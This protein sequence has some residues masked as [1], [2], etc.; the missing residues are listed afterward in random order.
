MDNPQ[1]YKLIACEILFRELSYC[2]AQSR[3]IIDVTFMPKGLHDMGQSKMSARLQA[4]IDQ[5]DVSQYAA[6]LFG[7]GLCNNG[8]RG[9]R[10]P[11]PMVLPRAHDCITLLMGSK[12]KYVA[13]FQDHPGTFY[14][15]PGWIERDIDPNDNPDSVMTQLGISRSYQDYVAKYGE[16][17]A[18]YLMDMLGDWVKHYNRIAYIDTQVSNPQAYQAQSRADAEERGWEYEEI[19]GSVDLLMRLLNG[20]WDAH[21]FLVIPPS[22]TLI[23]TYDDEIIGS[24]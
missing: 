6:I 3:N 23:P 20:E 18:R 22:Q 8:T 13:Y 15:S 17:N 5:T 1:R 14:K 2:A 24:V 16:E 12:E 10:A 21:D 9:L 4:E 19:Q 11:I 7:Y